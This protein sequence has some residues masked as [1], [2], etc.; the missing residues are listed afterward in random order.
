MAS[1]ASTTTTISSIAV[2]SGNT[3][4]VIALLQSGDVLELRIQELSPEMSDVGSNYEEALHLQ[5]QHQQVLQKLQNKQSPVE[6]LLSQADELIANQKPKA[7]VYS[8]MA[9]NLGLA[10]KN[11]NAQLE[12]RSIVLDTAVQYHAAAKKLSDELAKGEQEFSDTVLPDHVAACEARLQKLNEARKAILEASKRSLQPFQNLL[13]TLKEV[14]ST[15]DSRPLQP[16]AALAAIAALESQH[17]NLQDQRRKLG[18]LCEARKEALEK[19]LRALMLSKEL[20]EVERQLE[21]SPEDVALGD[22]PASSEILLHEHTTRI[23]SANEKLRDRMLKLL[24]TA[25]QIQDAEVEARAFD[26]M[27]RVTSRIERDEA[28]KRD[29][30]EAVEFFNE[31][32]TALN[33]LDQ[34]QI[35]VSQGP[36]QDLAAATTLLDACVERPLLLGHGILTRL[37]VGTSGVQD[38]VDELQCRHLQVRQMYEQKAADV[39]ESSERAISFLTQCN[40]LYKWCI[41][42]VQTFLERNSQL[43]TGAAAAHDFLQR[44]QK[45]LNELQA[46][47]PQMTMLLAQ[48]DSRS[49]ELLQLWQH[50]RSLLEQ[51]IRIAQRYLSCCKLSTQLMEDLKT[52]SD[53]GPERQASINENFMQF[54]HNANNFLHDAQRIQDTCLDVTKAVRHIQETL[55]QCHQL[56]NNPGSNTEQ[57]IKDAQKTME[58]A[59]KIESELYPAIPRELNRAET[60]AQYLGRHLDT[61]MPLVRT[62]QS[63]LDARIEATSTLQRKEHLIQQLRS[64]QQSFRRNISQYQDLVRAMISFFD[65]F[66]QLE[67]KLQETH[68]HEALLAEAKQRAE[69]LATLVDKTE[70]SEAAVLDRDKIHSLVDNQS[71]LLVA[72]LRKSHQDSQMSKFNEELHLINQQVRELTDSLKR[73]SSKCHVV[74]FQQRIQ[75]LERR[76]EVLSTSS[77]LQTDSARMELEELTSRWRNFHKEAMAAPPPQPLPI[78]RKEVKEVCGPSFVVPLDDVEVQEGAKCSLVCVLAGHPP[79]TVQWYKDGVSIRGNSDYVTT[80]QKLEDGTT[81]Q[82]LTIEETLADDSAKFC[83]KAINAAGLAETSCRLSV[84]EQARESAL[85]EVF[86]DALEEHTTQTVGG[87]L[88]EPTFVQ[89]LPAI[90]QLRP[91]EELRLECTVQGRPEPRV[92]WSKDLLP[93]RDAAKPTQEQGRAR[94]VLAGATENDSGTYTAVA[95]NKAGETACS[96][97]VKVAEDAPPP[98]PPRVLK[99]LEDLEVKPGPDPVTLE[100]VIVGRPEP[101]VIWYHNTQPIK[102]S[103]RV[104]LLFRGDKCSLLF[105]GIGT[106]NAG[107]YRCSAVNP[108]GSC[109]TEC[110]V[111]V[112]LSA[113]VFLEPLRDVTTD[114]GCRVVLTAK[115]WAP[116]P[117][118]VHWFKDG[119]ELLPSPDFQVSHDPDGTVKLL[120]P[121]VAGNNSGHYEV[122]ASNPGGRTR[123]GCRMHVRES[124]KAVQ[125]ATT[126]L[127]VSRTSK[128]TV[129]VS[130]SG[131]ELRLARSLPSELVVQ[132]GTKVCLSVASAQPPGGQLTASWFRSGQPITDSPDFRLTRSLENVAGTSL[133]V[134]SLTI[135]EAFPEDS[136]DLEVRVQGPNGVVTANTKLVVL[137]EDDEGTDNVQ[138][139]DEGIQ[140]ASEVKVYETKVPRSGPGDSTGLAL[141]GDLQMRVTEVTH[142]NEM[143]P[144]VSEETTTKI[145]DNA[146]AKD[147]VTEEVTRR[148]T[149][150]VTEITKTQTKELSTSRASRAAGPLGR[151]EPIPVAPE[152]KFDILEPKYDAPLLG[153]RPIRAPPPVQ[154]EQS[155]PS[156]FEPLSVRTSFCLETGQFQSPRSIIRTKTASP[157]WSPKKKAVVIAENPATGQ[158]VSA[159]VF[160]QGPEDV[161]AAPGQPATL[162]A[163]VTGCPAPRLR[164]FKDGQPVHGPDHVVGQPYGPAPWTA[165]LSIPEAFP[166]DSG[167]YVC[168]ASNLVGN[169]SACCRLTVFGQLLSRAAYSGSAAAGRALIRSPTKKGFDGHA[170]GNVV[171][172]IRRDDTV[173]G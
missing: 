117:P 33:K 151:V 115:L 94:L 50:L 126:Q 152:P 145:V 26:L 9:H 102:E 98:E 141:S 129:S 89:P 143:P 144:E 2:Q 36:V 90:A 95:K 91:G 12:H 25:K 68:E 123:T 21:R 135:S 7:Q 136:G 77:R 140:Q 157:V 5:Q 107:T 81:E 125:A 63:E 162:R 61:L 54:D 149:K 127:A 85:E 79:P 170:T 23:A 131:S 173:A 153:S 130:K 105:N 64:T 104:R 163:L 154:P 133:A 15:G 169:T 134:F 18:L 148:V 116:E 156:L 103:E 110:K 80:S 93:V 119:R 147:K 118:F 172:I 1:S 67:K 28:R 37:S 106:Q 160:L 66:A 108:M 31:A 142:V 87:V 76:I 46:R 167:V 86:I 55:D 48:D 112:P 22:S 42:V 3:R 62:I 111:R 109:Y 113:P 39:V 122:E 17:E 53:A 69:N 29:L 34:L 146:G 30:K 132:S 155:R 60:I 138:R 10:W 32:Q 97:Q 164:W 75:S 35:Q 11:L 56:K 92:S 19:R 171:W 38:K 82:R 74:E 8:A 57:L 43:D 51:R 121:K 58:S 120:I 40:S 4:L 45:M 47:E 44:H 96:C 166:E 84:R 159:P 73:D 139:R 13:Q 16:A 168:T 88:T 27:A 128:Q 150:R 72:S 65:Y 78:E 114:E 14:A 99:A 6:E 71:A 124:Q 100:C 70:P 161:Y 83:C 158:R 52:I 20:D 137:D 24:K 59:V 49:K 165:W 101:E 41:E